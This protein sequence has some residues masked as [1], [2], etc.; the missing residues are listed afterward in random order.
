ML[1]MK[2]WLEWPSRQCLCSVPAEVTLGASSWEHRSSGSPL[3]T[4]GAAEG[5]TEAPRGEV[6]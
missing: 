5:E 4:P 1:G 2:L 3:S 6:G